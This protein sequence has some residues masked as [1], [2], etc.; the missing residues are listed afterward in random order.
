M[1]LPVVD[2]MLT[3]LVFLECPVL[4]GDIA[5][6]S[7]DFILPSAIRF[8]VGTVSLSSSF[9]CMA[10]IWENWK[11]WDS[12]LEHCE[13]CVAG[14]VTG[15]ATEFSWPKLM[16]PPLALEGSTVGEGGLECSLCMSSRRRSVG[17]LE[18]T[19]GRG[20]KKGGTIINLRA[21]SCRSGR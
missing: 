11:S 15:I 6:K 14:A 7:C 12:W 9:S 10:A 2:A 3:V 13:D 18:E 20:K 1:R 17:I 19:T 4:M 21:Y 16:F 5:E 8:L